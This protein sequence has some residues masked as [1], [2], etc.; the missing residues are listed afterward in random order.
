MFEQFDKNEKNEN[1]K[2]TASAEFENLKQLMTQIEGKKHKGQ[3]FNWTDPKG[4]EAM[5]KLGTVA[6]QF[7]KKN[8]SSYHIRFGGLA[9]YAQ[10]ADPPEP[11]TW[12]VTAD[13]H[14]GTFVWD[15]GGKR[16][17]S[18]ELAEEIA[19]RLAAFYDGY[20]DAVSL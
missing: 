14:D 3:F 9:A 15:L 16:R 5:L 4:G 10:A 12:L 7:S 18:E 19:V 2:K 17:T 11:E 13:A 6:A 1:I 8:D 20:E